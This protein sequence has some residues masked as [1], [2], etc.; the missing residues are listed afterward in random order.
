VNFFFGIKSKE[1]DCELI[2]PKFSNSGKINKK[3]KLFQANIENNKWVIEDISN[4]QEGNFFLIK[5]MNIDNHKIFFLAKN[6][7]INQSNK[8][9]N[10]LKINELVNFSSYT[11]TEPDYRS[12]LKIYNHFTFSSYQSDYPFR[13]ISAKG[14]I[15]SSIYPLTNIDADINKIF[16]RNIYF[17]PEIKKSF[18]YLIDISKKKVIKKILICSNTT[19]EINLSKEQIGPN[20]YLYTKDIVGIPIYV[21]QKDNSLSMEHTHPPHH[22]IV[23]GEKFGLVKNLKK[24]FYEII[25]KEN[26]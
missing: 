17:L 22:Y 7:E 10:K 3:I 20:I 14:G 5:N 21:S 13:M 15:L 9:D 18:A 8:L 6:S 1:F 19:N 12:N 2:I 4:Y 26:I 23:G 25:D 16:F 24:K 11:D